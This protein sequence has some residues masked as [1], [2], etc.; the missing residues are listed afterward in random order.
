[1]RLFQLITVYRN[2][3][4]RLKALAGSC[5][6]FDGKRD[7]F[8]DDR[9]GASHI[10]LPV[11][12]SDES[13]FLTVGNDEAFLQSWAIQEGMRA[14][15]DVEDV[16][17]AQIEHHR[18]EVFYTTDPIRFGNAFLRRLPGC[19]RR[20]I[21][22]RAAPSPHLDFFDY[23]LVISNFPSILA[24]Y[25][26]R[27]A[28]TAP[29]SPSHDPALDAEASRTDRP[30]DVLFVGG[31]SQ[32]HRERALLL[33]RVAALQDRFRIAFH[34]DG[35][36]LSRLADTPLGLLPP[37]SRYRRP[38]AIRRLDRGS[39]FGRDLY[40]ALGSAKIVLNGAIDMAG[41]ERGNMRCFE[42]MGAGCLMVSDDGIYPPGFEAGRNFLAYRT[43]DE[44]AGMIEGA[45]RGWNGSGALASAGHDMI[46]S[47]YSKARQWEAFQALV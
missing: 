46:A 15:S 7:A 18:A 34:L 30:V 9:Y 44:A 43:I 22:W 1:M 8:L 29:F 11:L 10:L 17:L 3:L 26:S 25:R 20:T 31:F 41:K 4:P 12:C 13:A 21:A 38:A 33:E 16:L 2:Y 19:V 36:R 45:L 23:D 39:A 14:N 37:L 35:S 40:H 28:R 32:Y 42:A 24:D 5:P 6:T 27:G 47:Q